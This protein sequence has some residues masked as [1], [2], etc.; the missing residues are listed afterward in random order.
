EPDQLPTFK[1]QVSLDVLWRFVRQRLQSKKKDEKLENEVRS[2]LP[3]APENFKVRF[4]LD[5]QTEETLK[6]IVKSVRPYQLSSITEEELQQ[7][8]LEHIVLNVLPQLWRAER[9]WIA[10]VRQSVRNF[11]KGK[12]RESKRREIPLSDLVDQDL[13]SDMDYRNWKEGKDN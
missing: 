1:L 12:Y 11:Y 8:A 13:L 4:Q 10:Y 3:R 5:N 9:G 2:L 7:E 6:R